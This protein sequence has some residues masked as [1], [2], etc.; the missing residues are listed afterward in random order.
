MSGSFSRKSLR[1]FS[2]KTVKDKG[3]LSSISMSIFLFNAESKFFISIKSIS[4]VIFLRC[5]LPSVLFNGD[6]LGMR[7]NCIVFLINY[8]FLFCEFFRRLI[9]SLSSFK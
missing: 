6:C 1:D 9:I 3:S 5:Y 2:A 8:E 7:A 4:I